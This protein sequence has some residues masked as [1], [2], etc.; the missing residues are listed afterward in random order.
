MRVAIT[1]LGRRQTSTAPPPPLADLIAILNANDVAILAV[2]GHVMVASGVR[3]P[4][5]RH[6][7]AEIRINDPALPSPYWTRFAYIEPSLTN[8]LVMHVKKY[9]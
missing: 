6:A 1:L 4:A 3:L 9:A 7:E 2:P 8:V 5:L